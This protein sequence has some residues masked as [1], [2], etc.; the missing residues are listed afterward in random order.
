MFCRHFL[1]IA[2]GTFS[3]AMIL[4]APALAQT[5]DQTNATVGEKESLLKVEDFSPA[6]GRW[7][8]NTGLSYQSVDRGGFIPGFFLVTDPIGTVIT[9]PT[10]SQTNDRVDRASL[11]FGARYA[12][13][14]SVNLFG[15]ATGSITNV[16]RTTAPNVSQ[17]DTTTGFDTLNLGL[18]FRFSPTPSR[19][20]FTG[21]L[22]V[23]A[24]EESNDDYIHAKAFSAGLTMS[25]VVD[26]LILSASLNYSHFSSRD[27]N[28]VSSRDTADGEFKPG[29]VI[30][31]TPTIG[32]A[33]NP[34]INIS[35][36][37][38]IS[39][40]MGDERAGQSDQEDDVL[41]TVN[42]GLGYRLSR[43]TLLNVSGRA[44]V[45]GNNAVRLTSGLS[46]R[47]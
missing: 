19:T 7:S 36:G 32:F 10:L 37:M 40:K 1:T 20:N 47:F 11:S 45:G 26:P 15:Q 21:F 33:V 22:S 6:K 34:D 24:I 18:D 35:W 39:Y 2:T 38:G 5:V 41:S 27:Y 4:A 43:D 14:N 42:L 28:H 8:I 31:V 23:A 12:L 13:T 30:T 3:F 17:N 25:R 46:K 9:I 29:N 16:R 44:G